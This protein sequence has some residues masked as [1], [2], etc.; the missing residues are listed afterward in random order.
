MKHI[1]SLGPSWSCRA[2]VERHAPTRER[3]D[4]HLVGGSGR[5]S[6]GDGGV[7]AGEAGGVGGRRHSDMA[8]GRQGSGCSLAVIPC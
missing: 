1:E 2:G 8:V 6:P 4:L 5:P 7:V 3:R